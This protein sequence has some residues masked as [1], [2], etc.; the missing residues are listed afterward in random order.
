MPDWLKRKAAVGQIVRMPNRD[1]IE[2]DID[3]QLIVEYYSR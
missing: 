3:D 2:A 1:E